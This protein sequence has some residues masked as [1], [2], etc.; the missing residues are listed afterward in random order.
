MAA[1]TSSSRWQVLVSFLRYHDDPPK[2]PQEGVDVQCPPFSCSAI[3]LDRDSLP[4]SFA[5]S[6]VEDYVNISVTG[7]T[8]LQRRVHQGNTPRND[9]ECSLVHIPISTLKRTQI[10]AS[11]CGWTASDRIPPPHD[12]PPT[13]AA[14]FAK[15][16]RNDIMVSETRLSE[17]RISRAPHLGAR[18]PARSPLVRCPALPRT[19]KRERGS[20]STSQGRSTSTLW[21]SPRAF[22]WAFAIGALEIAGD[23]LGT[24]R[25][26]SSRFNTQVF[27]CDDDTL[28]RAQTQSA[29]SSR[30]GV[31][32]QM[33]R[34]RTGCTDHSTALRETVLVRGWRS[35]AGHRNLRGPSA[36]ADR[37]SFV[38]R[39]Q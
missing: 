7:E 39:R 35:W 3:N 22:A 6:S 17:H 5:T 34:V 1:A 33:L 9:K 4:T 12:S 23:L 16:S 24:A 29:L 36:Q 30:Y 37:H 19:A 27:E 31:A 32:C 26:A 11:G 21:M 15:A 28:K 10:T 13:H 25:W 14:L 18:L 8:L 20:T 38:L 2:L